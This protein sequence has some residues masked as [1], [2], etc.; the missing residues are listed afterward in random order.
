M[1]T[2][3]VTALTPKLSAYSLLMRMVID[4]RISARE[5]ETLFLQLYQDDP[6]DWPID[7]LDVLETLFADLDEL[8]G[9]GDPANPGRAG[10]ELQRRAQIAYSS[11]A[12]L[13]PTV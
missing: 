11:L 4:Q 6:T 13:A 2:T 10:S 7:V 8:F 5:F 12:E 1:S 9:Q 3:L